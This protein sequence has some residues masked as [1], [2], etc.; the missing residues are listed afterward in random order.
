MNTHAD[1]ETL[2]RAFVENRSEDA[3]RRLVERYTGLV[4]GVA[5][6]CVANRELAE[7][8]AQNVFTIFARKAHQL[9]AEGGLAPWLHRTA[10]FEATKLQRAEVRRAA[11]MKTLLDEPTPSDAG[12][13]WEEVR[14]LLDEAIERL[15]ETDRRVLLLHYFDGLTFRQIASRI[16]FS[17]EAAQKRSVRALEKLAGLLKSK[18]AAISATTLGTGLS[19]QL[20]EAAPAGLAATLANTALPSVGSAASG[21][22]AGSGASF[23]STLTQAMTLT[24]ATTTAA[25]VVAAAMA[26]PIGVQMMVNY[27]AS[28][29]TPITTTAFAIQSN[30][31][32]GASEATATRPSEKPR[33]IINGLDLDALARELARLPAEN[34][35]EVELR[36]RR[37]M[38]T[39]D[40]EQ[41]RAVAELLREAKN[42]EALA[43]VSE[44]LFACWA[45]FNPNEAVVTAL[46]LP[47][48]LKWRSLDGALV[49]WVTAK[50]DAA[51]AW[52]EAERDL[53]LRDV[54]YSIVFRQIARR[55]PQASA[56]RGLVVSDES[57][58]RAA[59]LA[60]LEVWSQ[61][62]PMDA[63]GWAE[64]RETEA[65]RN[66]FA[67]QL[68]SSVN[69]RNPQTALAV[70]QAASN[71][72]VRS[73]G[74]LYALLKW[75]HLD[76]VSAAQAFL[77]L[78]EPERREHTL[79]QMASSLAGSNLRCAR[80]FVAQI[81]QGPLHDT[82]LGS[83]VSVGSQSDP[84]SVADFALPLADSPTQR[85][86]FESFVRRWYGRDDAGLEHWFMQLPDS[87][88]KQAVAEVMS[89]LRAAM[90]R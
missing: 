3:F 86:H 60:S 64:S 87:T 13:P 51:L 31:S 30:A 6:R 43:G 67:A 32:V 54:H 79:D 48:H 76:S 17:N 44:A 66:D 35:P 85:A 68:I 72:H 45:E 80:E 46:S 50:P 56:N 1:D 16:G 90:N 10:F 37:L 84:A 7:E 33:R 42:V 27:H 74:S 4:F 58:R 57:M 19:T 24:K 77:T 63:L 18:G 5:L 83:I 36:L 11:R 49:T 75:C 21:A 34:Q 52:L 65:Q 8:A 73:D 78:P 14:P 62:A 29:R 69:Q 89:K 82:A 71:P 25:V 20:A 88:A 22:G 53:P 41:V 55:D 26:L 12:D 70:A 38:M 9:R 81:P 2:L 40:L 28:S 39:L 15:S 61:T 47:A 23:I 59:V